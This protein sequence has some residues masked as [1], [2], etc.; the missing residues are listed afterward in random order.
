[1]SLRFRL[2]HQPPDLYLLFDQVLSTVAIS[3]YYQPDFSFIESL[4]RTGIFLPNLS[5]L[6]IRGV[7]E[8]DAL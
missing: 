2:R 3:Y 5:H 7:R 1:M 8:L 6:T 4:A